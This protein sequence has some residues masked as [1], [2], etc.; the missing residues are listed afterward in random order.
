M[1]RPKTI[2]DQQ[3]AQVLELK[4]KHSYS[5][6]AAITGLPLGTVRSIVRRSGLLADNPKHRALFT[7]PPIQHSTSTGLTIVDIPP[8]QAVTGVKEV[9]AMLWLR[10][11][12][13]TGKPEFIEK[14]LLAAKKIKTPAKQLEDSY[15]KWLIENNTG[16]FFAGLGAMG[17]A[18]LDKLADRTIKNKLLEAELKARLGDDAECVTTEAEQFCFD[19]VGG[20]G[21]LDDDRESKAEALFNAYPE[22][23]PHTLSDCVHELQY[24]N[25][26]YLMRNAISSHDDPCA[27]IREQFI[28]RLLAKIRPRSPSESKAVLKHLIETDALNQSWFDTDEILEN[29]LNL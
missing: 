23:L 10:E 3:R 20:L 9:D 14:A 18:D 12:I 19:A 13:K 26:L 28:Q 11:M 21:A 1:A 27:S 6:V 17:F 22:Y 5:E 4:R 8:Q 29:L 7:L 25:N 24:W 16:N 2:T 15:S